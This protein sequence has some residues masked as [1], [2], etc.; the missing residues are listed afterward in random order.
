MYRISIEL[1]FDLSEWACQMLSTFINVER[2]V[3][4][5][6]SS[7]RWCW[8]F[9]LFSE[10]PNLVG[11]LVK[12]LGYY[13]NVAFI[14]YSCFQFLDCQHVCDQYF[15]SITHWYQQKTFLSSKY[16]SF[17][18]SITRFHLFKVDLDTKIKLQ[19]SETQSTFI[20]FANKWCMRHVVSNFFLLSIPIMI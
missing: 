18:R 10:I 5:V 12:S 7:V 13:V 8:G 2:V 17:H 3:L 9:T 20:L 1:T 19:T 11:V 14:K 15:S 16:V 4:S 6:L